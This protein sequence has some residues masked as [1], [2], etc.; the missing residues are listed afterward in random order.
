[1]PSPL[2]TSKAYTLSGTLSQEL[3]FGR[4]PRGISGRAVE[5]RFVF[6]QLPPGRYALTAS[7]QGFATLK[8]EEVAL[9]AGQSANLDLKM[10]ASGVAEAV[11]ASA[12]DR[13]RR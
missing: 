4:P 12:V 7:K 5:G 1:M 6:L 3:F 8:Q 11:T 9:T 13:R 2:T 10:K